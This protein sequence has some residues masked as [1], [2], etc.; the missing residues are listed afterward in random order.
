MLGK[1]PYN[2]VWC[3]GWRL[4]TVRRELRLWRLLFYFESN[5]W[6]ERSAFSHACFAE[7]RFDAFHS[8][9]IL[10]DHETQITIF[11]STTMWHTILHVVFTPMLTKVAR[12]NTTHQCV[13]VYDGVI[14]SITCTICNNRLLMFY[15]TAWTSCGSCRWIFVW[16]F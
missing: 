6:K 16:I 12:I 11:F 10:I 7:F 1:N 5:L 2:N 9:T 3:M 4:L 14:P 8:V 13:V 15:C